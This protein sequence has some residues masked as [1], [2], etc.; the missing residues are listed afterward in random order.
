ME[1]LVEGEQAA[2]LPSGQASEAQNPAVQQAEAQNQREQN[3]A[4]Q[5]LPLEE[6]ALL[7]EELPEAH[8][9][10]AFHDDQD[11]EPGVRLAVLPEDLP[12]LEAAL[13]GLPEPRL[14]EVHNWEALPGDPAGAGIEEVPEELQDSRLA[15]PLEHQEVPGDHLDRQL[16]ELGVEARLP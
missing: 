5:A 12:E 1:Q 14:A 16:P 13:L 3:P 4:E 10:H 9:L 11:P 2:V 15:D 8:R 7:V 6:P